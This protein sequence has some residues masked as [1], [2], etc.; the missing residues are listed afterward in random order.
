[1]SVGPAG[2]LRGKD[3]EG[4]GWRLSVRCHV[5]ERR[6]RPD[7]ME[8]DRAVFYGGDGVEGGGPFAL[9]GKGGQLYG[10]GFSKPEA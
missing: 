6:K 8:M 7:P 2:V 3:V 10:D 1:M 4:T 5:W 9:R